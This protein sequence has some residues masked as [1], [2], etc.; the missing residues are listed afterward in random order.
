[1][2]MLMKNDD[3]DTMI[4]NHRLYSIMF[5]FIFML[6]MWAHGVVVSHPLCM[7]KALGS[8]P[9]GSIYVHRQ[10]LSDVFI[11]RVWVMMCV[12]MLFSSAVRK[13]EI[14]SRAVSLNF[15]GNHRFSI[16]IWAHGVVVSHPLRMRKAL[17]SIPNGSIFA[18][19]E[20]SWDCRQRVF[21]HEVCVFL[22]EQ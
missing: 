6:Y 22:R 15:W 14:W 12:W 10:R 9:S 19:T 2:N 11:E 4:A 21:K 7:R 3:S 8:I 18:L 1:M 13:C 5:N 20:M 17:G 16:I